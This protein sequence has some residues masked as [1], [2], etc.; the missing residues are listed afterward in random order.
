MG[1][2]SGNGNG[3]CRYVE[4]SYVDCSILLHCLTS[5]IKYEFAKK[6]QIDQI[7][8]R[9]VHFHE[10][11]INHSLYD[12]SVKISIALVFKL[13]VVVSGAIQ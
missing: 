1:K 5:S 6:S 10:T 12:G 9:T 13:T 4:H 11:S 2:N 8:K 3:V 7:A